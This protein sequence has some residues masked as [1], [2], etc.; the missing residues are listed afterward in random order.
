MKNTEKDWYSIEEACEYL[1]ISKPTI[2]RWMKAGRISYFKVG[3][4]TRF[5]QHNLDMVAEKKVS[6]K[7]G[8]L[9]AS[10]CAVCG[11]S[12]MIDGDIRSTGK[13]YFKP[14]KTKF[15]TMMESSV[16]VKALVC[17]VCGHIQ[18][19]ADAGKLG[20]LIPEKPLQD[21]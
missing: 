18:L 5:K 17:I 3:N 20:R 14:K 11:N 12:E 4:S 8:S 6:S 1:N 16:N 7:E 21:S 9:S 13:M 15:L 10:K 19:S 2:F